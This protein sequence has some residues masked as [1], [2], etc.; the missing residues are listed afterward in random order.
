MLKNR[1]KNQFKNIENFRTMK[2]QFFLEVKLSRNP[3]SK[4]LKLWLL[5]ITSCTGRMKDC[6]R[7][8]FF[9]S[10]F[11]YHS[12]TPAMAR[13]IR[14]PVEIMVGIGIGDV[15]SLCQFSLLKIT[16]CAGRMKDCR[17]DLYS[18]R[19]FSCIIDTSYRTHFE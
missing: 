9:T 11:L 13:M 14:M 12:L 17:F 3:L 8:L 19:H 2:I 18:L 5:K 16:S 15:N 1:A 6:I 7:S 10:F 4:S